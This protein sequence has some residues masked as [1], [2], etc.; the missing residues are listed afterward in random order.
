MTDEPLADQTAAQP[1]QP[2]TIRI[3]TVQSVNP[4]SVLLGGQNGTIITPAALGILNDYFPLVGDTVVLVGQSVEGAQ[5]SA[6]SWSILGSL[7]SSASRRAD[8]T[9]YA[10]AWTSAAGPQPAIGNGT[11]TGRYMKIGRNTVIVEVGLIF[12]TTTTAGNGQW[13]FSAP[14]TGSNTSMNGA[15]GA[16][17]I[18]D[19][20]V[21]NRACIV[22]LANPATTFFLTQAPTTA[23]GSASQTWG[24]GDALRF[25]I[26]YEA[27]SADV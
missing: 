18:F 9:N 25:T 27:A 3:G 1:G 6:S 24:T 8:W 26:I 22:N 11:L 7:S 15:T 21:A 19:S 4:L 23:V 17:Y 13:F 12:G 16:A 5:S 20:G 14:F 2:S 10:I